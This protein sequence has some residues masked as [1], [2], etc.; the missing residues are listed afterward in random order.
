MNPLKSY[1]LMPC[2]VLRDD[3]DIC[4]PMTPEILRKT[5]LKA[6]FGKTKKKRKKAKQLLDRI[7]FTHPTEK[8]AK[9]DG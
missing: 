9:V 4:L 2:F 7:L 3:P 1:T 6:I 8:G 5:V